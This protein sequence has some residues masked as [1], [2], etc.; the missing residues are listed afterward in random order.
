[1][2]KWLGILI[3]FMLFVPLPPAYADDWPIREQEIIDYC[4]DSSRED[5]P[6]RGREISE[7][8]ANQEILA[9]EPGTYEY[10]NDVRF[11]IYEDGYYV[12]TLPDSVYRVS[13]TIW[14]DLIRGKTLGG[15]SRP[16]LSSVLI[17]NRVMPEELQD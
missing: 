13:G 9:L 12:V 6:E 15:C 14:H 4:N 2:G 11:V 8:S 1:M 17:R 3:V 5:G 7:E 10:E 16:Q